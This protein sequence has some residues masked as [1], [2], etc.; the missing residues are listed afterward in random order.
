M[1]SE[2]LQFDPP[3]RSIGCEA[4]RGGGAALAGGYRFETRQVEVMWAQGS[5]KLGEEVIG[6][7]GV[8]R[9]PR[10]TRSTREQVGQNS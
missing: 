6:A 4:A 7:I 8:G 9:A 3:R 2:I 1:S 5:L 10:V